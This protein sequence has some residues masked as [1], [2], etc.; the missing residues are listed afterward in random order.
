[1]SF[2]KQMCPFARQQRKLSE[3]S[4]FLKTE[5]SFRGTEVFFWILKKTE[6]SFF[7]FFFF[8]E[9]SLSLFKKLLTGFIDKCLDFSVDMFQ[10][11]T[12]FNM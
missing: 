1:M 9:V 12:I 7:A 5:V 10:Q 11:K 4:V 6:G 2:G 8:T 3:G